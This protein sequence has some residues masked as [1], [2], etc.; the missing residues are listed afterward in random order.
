MHQDFAH[1]ISTNKRLQV[2]LLEFR[3]LGRARPSSLDRLEPLFLDVAPVESG[4]V[5][6]L[7]MLLYLHI[8]TV[9]V[10]ESV[11]TEVGLVL[12]ELVAI[13]EDAHAHGLE[14]GRNRGYDLGI[15]LVFAEGFF[16]VT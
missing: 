5:D 4:Q 7:I 16:G 11:R 15:H 12:A 10:A 8:E 13:K 3:Q 9:S 14:V 6:H 1:V 2:E